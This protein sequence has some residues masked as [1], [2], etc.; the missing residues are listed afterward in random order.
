MEEGRKEAPSI[1]KTFLRN[2]LGTVHSSDRTTCKDTFYLSTLLPA[3]E[4]VTASGHQSG[5]EQWMSC[6]DV[7]AKVR[8]REHENI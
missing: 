3:T 4:I 8:L 5:Q 1:R 6:R 2:P 7:Y